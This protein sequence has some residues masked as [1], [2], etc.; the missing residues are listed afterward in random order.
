MVLSFNGLETSK[1]LVIS[2]KKVIENLKCCVAQAE[3]PD[4]KR[5]RSGRHALN[6]HV[7][8]LRNAEKMT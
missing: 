3:S 4:R 8:S 7:L 2:D 5:V 6:Q 1:T